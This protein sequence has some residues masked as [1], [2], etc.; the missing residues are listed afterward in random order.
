MPAPGSPIPRVNVLGVRISAVHMERALGEIE[1]WIERGE[2]R[3]A[4]A[5]SVN[6]VMQAR[7]DAGLR[8]A[9]NGAGLATPDGM[10]LVWLARWR[11]FSDVSRVYGPDLMLALCE[12]AARKGYS[13]YFHGGAYGVAEDLARALASRFPGLAVAG[14]PSPP[15]RPA[16]ALEP[17]DAI[18]QINAARPDIVW[19]G[20]GSPKQVWWVAQHRALLDAPV[21]IAVGAAFDFHT[22]RLP[23][24]PRWMQASGLEWAFRLAHEPRRLWRRYLIQ[25]PLFIAFVLMQ[26]AGFASFD[27]DG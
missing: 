21:L 26:A 2:R 10:P 9:L 23:Q 14:A 22:G 25:N 7:Q 18:E 13:N 12:R 20:L 17:P 4:C 6:D 5:C 24:A 16:K 19:V 1:G 8:A 11:G 15:F 3:Y 27:A